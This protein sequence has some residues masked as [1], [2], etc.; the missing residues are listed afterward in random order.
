MHPDLRGRRLTPSEIH[1]PKVTEK[2]Q[3][4]QALLSAP[5]GSSP[6]HLEH[7]VAVV[8]KA[9]WM[10]GRVTSLSPSSRQ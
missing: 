9:A 6:R 2:E 10:V 8:T 1:L 4:K 5:L 7:C 3:W